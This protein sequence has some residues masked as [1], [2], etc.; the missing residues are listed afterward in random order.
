[1]SDPR[2]DRAALIARV[3]AAIAT[4]ANANDGSYESENIR[5]RL[6]VAEARAL[7]A[8]LTRAASPPG[9][10]SGEG[11]QPIETAPKDGTA[12]LLFDRT[13]KDSP[14]GGGI[15]FGFYYNDAV[16][17]LWACDGCEA[18]PTHWMPLP[19]P[20]QESSREET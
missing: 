6:S 20:P 4:E 19:A 18:K 10:S 8:A 5:L 17:W 3:Q 13:N 14:D 9:P 7:L 12:V 2:P 11:W 15:D 16:R 1:M